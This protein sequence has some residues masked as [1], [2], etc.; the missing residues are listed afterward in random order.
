MFTNNLVSG[1]TKTRVMSGAFAA[2]LMAFSFSSWAAP[3]P[4]PACVF[5]QQ[6]GEAAWAAAQDNAG[7]HLDKCHIDVTDDKLRQRVQSGYTGCRKTGTASTW[8]N[9]EVMWKTVGGAIQDFCGEPEPT[10][11]FVILEPQMKGGASDIVGR[12]YRKSG[13]FD[14]KGDGKALVIMLRKNKEWHVLT[15]Y[16]Q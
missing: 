16:P 13:F 14:I 12:G 6:G 4:G 3:L 5:P 10:D 2:T 8:L 15:G 9:A 1:I 11:N 7:G